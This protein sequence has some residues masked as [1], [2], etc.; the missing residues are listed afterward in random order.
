MFQELLAWLVRM[1]NA[2]RLLPRIM[3]SAPSPSLT[4]DPHACHR[5]VLLPAEAENMRGG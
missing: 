5:K 4:T 3:P 2:T 1:S